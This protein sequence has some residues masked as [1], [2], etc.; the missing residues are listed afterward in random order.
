MK[1][2]DFSELLSAYLD[3]ELEPELVAQLE[4]HLEDC[5]Y[6]KNML[7]EI[8]EIKY[9]LSSL[10]EVEPPQS[11]HASIMHA[12][13]RQVIEDQN[14]RKA[15]KVAVR[16]LWLKR[17][18]VVLAAC[19]I[20][21]AISPAVRSTFFGPELLDDYGTSEDGQGEMK[22][23]S[24]GTSDVVLPGESEETDSSVVEP[25]PQESVIKELPPEGDESAQ[26]PAPVEEELPPQDVQLSEEE[27]KE[28]EIEEEA[29]EEGEFF[30]AL[31]SAPV[32][33]QPKEIKSAEVTVQVSSDVL[34]DVSGEI[35]SAVEEAGGEVHLC[36]EHVQPGEENKPAFCITATLPASALEQVLGNLST[37]GSLVESNIIAHDVTD[38]YD[39]VSCTIQNKVGQ[40]DKLA[41]AI[42]N[43]TN[44]E[45]VSVA[46]EE[47]LKLEE[48]THRLRREQEL[49]D[50][51]SSEASLLLW[52]IGE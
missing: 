40:R 26:E 35:R 6:C 20:I 12:V 13:N 23:A 5:A 51:L 31:K 44:L 49:L 28:E 38:Y 22:S 19:L 3:G 7:E 18:S 50:D 10:Q 29:P 48:E 43:A 1:Y 45:D 34:N 41:Q 33:L 2:C 36:F 14:E 32:R 27:E 39:F 17:V 52:V 46:E 37:W 9:A 8:K 11:L 21:L 47:L 4:D 42:E 30:M 25:A 24:E 15:R 16:N